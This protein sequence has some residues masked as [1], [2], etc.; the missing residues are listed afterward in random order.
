MVFYMDIELLISTMSKDTNQVCSMLE[1]SNVKCNALVVVQ[2]DNEGY[3]EVSR[4]S[5]KIRIFFSKERGLSKSRNLAL[6]NCAARYGY[7]MDDDVVLK[8]GAVDQIVMAMEADL[9]D[10]GTCFFE[11]EDGRNSMPGYK[12]SFDHNFLTAAKVASIEICVR[13][14]SIREKK[15][16]FDE[17][18][19]LGTE[20]PS[21]EEYVFITDCLKNDLK[22][23]YYPMCIGTHPN[24]TSGEDFYTS[25]SRVLAKREMMKRVFG[26]KAF[27]FVF[28]FWLKKSP[29][30][31]KNGFFIEF[32]KTMFLGVR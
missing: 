21:G 7:I 26:R 24:V 3:K 30:V 20:L 1:R 15:I 13:V 10:V 17:R 4:D 9:A 22:V 16:A 2:G 8:D 19:G 11:Y 14:A 18:F 31:I 32:T 27:F 6:S 29:E 25:Y 5:Q 28:L 12:N 23:K